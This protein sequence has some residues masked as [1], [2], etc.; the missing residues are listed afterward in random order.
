MATLLE[1]GKAD[2]PA[3]YKGRQIVPLEGLSLLP[4]FTDKPGKTHEYLF[5]E[6]LGNMAVMKGK[7]KLVSQQKEGNGKWHCTIWKPTARKKGTWQDSTPSWPPGCFRPIRAGQAKQGSIR[8]SP[9]NS[10]TNRTTIM[11][12]ALTLTPARL[13]RLD[14]SL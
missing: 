7:W 10:W 13:Y 3:N 4:C 14:D 8:R 11:N 9:K 1:A 6:H 12:E 2:Y 5:W